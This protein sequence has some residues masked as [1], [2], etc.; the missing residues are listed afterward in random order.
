MQ[1]KKLPGILS[2]QNEPKKWKPE[3]ANHNGRHNQGMSSLRKA[4][5]SP[6]Y[7]LLQLK[8]LLSPLSFSLLSY[9]FFHLVCLYFL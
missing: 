1:R 6:G 7:H 9:L 5:Y 4:V 8:S 2:Y 3:W